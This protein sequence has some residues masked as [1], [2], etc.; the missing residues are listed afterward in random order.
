MYFSKPTTFLKKL[1]PETDGPGA[2][3]QV[4][5]PKPRVSPL[6]GG[7]PQPRPRRRTSGPWGSVAEAWGTQA[8]PLSAQLVLSPPLLRAERRRKVWLT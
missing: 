7:Q 1:K 4:C 3:E 6:P 8:R 5:R 2:Q